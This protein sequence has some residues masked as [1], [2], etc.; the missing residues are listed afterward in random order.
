MLGALA[1]W[2]SRNLAT[3]T[4]KGWA[5]R[6][7][8]G[9]YAGRLPFGT[10]KGEAGVPVPDTRP[11]DLN[12]RAASNYQGLLLAFQRA[13]DGAT[14]A[15]VAE[16]LNAAGY[17]PS[18]H[19]RRALGNRFYVGE[20]PIGK[21]GVGGWHKGAHEPLV[22]I[23]LFE[24][25]QRQRSRR[26]KHRRSVSVPK[27]VRTLALSGLARCA[28]CGEAMHR[29]G[30]RLY[31]WGRRQIIGCRA[32]SAKEESAQREL[33]E[34][35]QRLILPEDT[36]RRILSAYHEAQ[37]EAAERDAE[38]RNIESQLRRLGDLYQMAT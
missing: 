34:Y 31:C 15:E 8:R 10:V 21:R 5:E 14:D 27:T 16:S 3:E 18:P 17:R 11:V 30:G 6:K 22:P 36:K 33:G 20:L 26:T 23:E 9:L 32:P 13:A 7:Q 12:G 24:T 2:Y 38:R 35:L 29:E 1:E 4:R 25:V 28:D 19:A 37:P